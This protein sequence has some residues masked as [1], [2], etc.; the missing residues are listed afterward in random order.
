V[1][2]AEKTAGV[3]ST[4][5]HEPTI[6]TDSNVGLVI[7]VLP[8]GLVARIC[9]TRETKPKRLSWVVRSGDKGDLR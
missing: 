8:C 3:R 7:T 4:S 5:G 6:H 1:K 9:P 2:R